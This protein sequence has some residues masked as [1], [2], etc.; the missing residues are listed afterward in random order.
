MSNTGDMGVEM[1][2]PRFQ[3]KGSSLESLLPH[4]FQN[5][6]VPPD[7]DCNSSGGCEEEGGF[8]CD[9]PRLDEGVGVGDLLD[10]DNDGDGPPAAPAEPQ[11]QPEYAHDA[12]RDGSC[13]PSAPHEQPH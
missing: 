13:W 10:S 11:P 2:I 8:D 4:W 3:V 12:A 1:G 9:G 5:R 7:I 6:V